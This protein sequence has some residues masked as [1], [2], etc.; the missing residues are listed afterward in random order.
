MKEMPSGVIKNERKLFK[1]KNEARIRC[2]ARDARPDRDE[3]KQKRKLAGKICR[4]K[5]QKN[6]T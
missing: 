2:F 6:D 1:Q 3:Y 5:K 4:K